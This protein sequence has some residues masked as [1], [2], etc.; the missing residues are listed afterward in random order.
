MIIN[1]ILMKVAQQ[2]HK[3]KICKSVLCSLAMHFIFVLPHKEI[4]LHNERDSLQWHKEAIKAIHTNVSF[5]NCDR[6]RSTDGPSPLLHLQD[7]HRHCWDC[8]WQGVDCR[9]EC[10]YCHCQN[11]DSCQ[12]VSKG[13]GLSLARFLWDFQLSTKH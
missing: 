10:E 2:R 9:R 6:A 13:N 3:Y 11:C 4:S 7:C 8:R 1:Y 12:L 5:N